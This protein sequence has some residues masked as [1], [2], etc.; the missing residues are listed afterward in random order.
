MTEVFLIRTQRGLEPATAYDADLVE[1]FPLR[2][3][4]R[5]I[6]HRA[7]S[8]PQHRLF[9]AMIG[10]VA[11]ACG[12]SPQDM[13]DIIKLETGHYRTIERKGE[14]YRIPESIAFNAMDGDAFRAFFD[15]ALAVIVEETGIRQPDLLDDLRAMFPALFE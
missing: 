1:A 14:R 9:F 6:V 4:I 10:H 3:Q 7:R 11:R 15:Q 12:R 5:A 13:L 8:V 2:Q